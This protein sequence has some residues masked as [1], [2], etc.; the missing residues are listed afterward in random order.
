MVKVLKYLI[1]VITLFASYTCRKKTSIEAE[2]Y[3]YALAEPI[4]NARVVLVERKESGLFVSDVSC[5]EIASATTDAKG[6]CSF[7]KEKLKNGAKH[8]YYLAVAEAY[9]KTQDYPCGGK[10]SG[11]LDAG[12]SHIQALESSAFDAF[13]KV[14][15]N[16]LLNPSQPGDSLILK[17][18][19]P[20]YQ[21]P[22][23]QYPRGGGRIFCKS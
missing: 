5:M 3:N 20:R 12:G 17:I 22:G 2:V 10:T 15:Y 8:T 4:A 21:V 14:Q 19:N 23:E 16:N 9:E 11:F 6:N 1:V 7:D 18:V 13:F